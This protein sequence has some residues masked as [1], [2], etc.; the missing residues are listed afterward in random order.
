MPACG[1]WVGLGEDITMNPNKRIAVSV[2]GVL[3]LGGGGCG[4][5]GCLLAG[6]VDG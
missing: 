3:A 1:A 2:L 5:R 4:Q 6:T